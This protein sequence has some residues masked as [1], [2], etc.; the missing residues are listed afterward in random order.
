[1]ATVDAPLVTSVVSGFVSVVTTPSSL[2]LTLSLAGLACLA[3]GFRRGALVSLTPG[4]VGVLAFGVTSLSEV[5]IAPL[6]ARFPPVDLAS[7]EA[8]FGLIVLGAGLNEVYASHTGV[9]LELEEG[10][11]AV[12]VAALLARRYP[13]AR[14]IVSGGGSAWAPPPLRAADGMRR[15]L[16]EL[17]VPAERI[18]ID[19]G[20]QTTIQRVENTLR[21]VGTDRDRTWWV[22]TPAHRMPRVIGVYRHLGFDPVPY[23]IDFQR[24]PPFSLTYLYGLTDG[25]ALTDAGAK[26]WLGL[27]LYDLTGKTDT[28]FPGPIPPAD[29]VTAAH[30][31]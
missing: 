3:A 20:S 7:A 19:A 13:E 26:E 12:Q 21:L 10:G 2:F 30:S 27:T 22:I 1:M 31:P 5:L 15:V 18:R 4:L 24:M 9:P 23:P 25:F 16:M 14:T 6:V 28:L 11:E 29:L 8:P 17:G